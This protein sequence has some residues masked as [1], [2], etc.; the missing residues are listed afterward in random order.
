MT[1]R[2]RLQM[3]AFEIKFLRK[4]EE[5]IR[6]AEI[7]ES[8]S[9]ESLLLR[10]KRSQLRWFGQVNRMTQIPLLKQTLYAKVNGKRPVGQ[11]RWLDYIKDLGRNRLGLRPSKMLVWDFVQVGGWRSV[12]A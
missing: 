10:I 6:N 7:H 9:I 1:E 11:T 4:I 5:V 3:L 8:L 12:A 2:V